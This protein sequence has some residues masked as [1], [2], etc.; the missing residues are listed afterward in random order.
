MFCKNILRNL[1][2]VFGVI[3]TVLI[4][5]PNA[6]YATNNIDANR[7][8]ELQEK[9]TEVRPAQISAMLLCI[10][11]AT[12]IYIA[13]NCFRKNSKDEKASEV[14]SV[15]K[16]I[17]IIIIISFCTIATLELIINRADISVDM[18]NLIV[19][20][21]LIVDFLFMSSVVSG[22]FCY[23]KYKEVLPKWLKLAYIIGII[24]MVIFIGDTMN[25]LNL[26]V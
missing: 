5:T 7:M 4:L 11:I 2:I 10:I 3:I 26:T 22:I 18:N 1:I 15:A 24:L 23:R 12:V 8:V 6:I 21:L 17:G 20:I 25:Q 13:L 19:N 16:L 14:S 9:V